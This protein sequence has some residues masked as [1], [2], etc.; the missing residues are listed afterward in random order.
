MERAEA[1]RGTN[2][3]LNAETRSLVM[4]LLTGMS[5][6]SGVGGIRP[7][8]EQVLQEAGMERESLLQREP[9]F[10]MEGASPEQNT[11]IE[12]EPTVWPYGTRGCRSS[13]RN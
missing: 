6:G 1:E 12:A 9:R 11:V 8:G 10:M 7:T 4:S 2:D 5:G 3:E 13:C